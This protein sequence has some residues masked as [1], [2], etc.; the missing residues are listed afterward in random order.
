MQAEMEVE[1][2]QDTLPLE[3]PLQETGPSV[4]VAA[5]TVVQQAMLPLPTSAGGHLFVPPR[6][7]A[8]EP[9]PAE[10]YMFT[11]AIEA[12]QIIPCAS[13]PQPDSE[14]EPE[15]EPEQEAESEVASSPPSLNAGLTETGTSMSAKTAVDIWP[16][17]HVPTERA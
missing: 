4:A 5:A 17:K 6:A 8:N 3:D 14:L 12:T 11:Q 10:S 13:A 16:G 7:P 2:T 1:N 15:P 9:F